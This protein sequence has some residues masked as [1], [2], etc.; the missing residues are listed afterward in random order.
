[1]KE[2]IVQTET[3]T[4]DEQQQL[5]GWGIDVFG[6]DA[7]NLTWRPM[8]LH[9]V[10]KINEQAVGHLGLIRE[11]LAIGG[12]LFDIA[13]VGDIITIPEMRGK[14]IAQ[15]LMSHAINFLFRE[16][17]VDAG[18]LFCFEKLVPYYQSLGWKIVNNPV[19]VLQPSGQ[20][21]FPNQLMVF[22]AEGKKWPEGIIEI[23]SLPW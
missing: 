22:T 21:K 13:G 16:W 8:E 20:V 14:G 17:K 23:S 15:K 3:L 9:F 6:G 7:Q 18:I 2:E 10:M 12:K 11:Q 4:N 1:M 19:Y 5:F